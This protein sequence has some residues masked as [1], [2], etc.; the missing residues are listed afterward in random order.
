[1]TK[2]FRKDLHVCPKHIQ[3]KTGDIIAILET[4]ENLNKSGFD[5]TKMPGQNSNENYYRIRVGNS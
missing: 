5:Y 4:A 2:G 1:M 3:Q